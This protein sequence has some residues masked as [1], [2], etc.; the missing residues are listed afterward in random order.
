MKNSGP[1]RGCSLGGEGRYGPHIIV[2]AEFN[3]AECPLSTLID[4][5]LVVVVNFDIV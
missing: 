2:G 4:V 3:G 5:S 1:R